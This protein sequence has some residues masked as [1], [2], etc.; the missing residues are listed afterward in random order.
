MNKFKYIAP[1]FVLLFFSECKKNIVTAT[2]VTHFYYDIKTNPQ[3]QL[4]SY[5]FSN[6][7]IQIIGSYKYTGDT[8]VSIKRHFSNSDTKIEIYQRSNNLNWF[9]LTDTVPIQSAFWELHSCHWYDF[10]NNAGLPDIVLIGYGRFDKVDIKNYLQPRYN[11]YWN[12]NDLTLIATRYFGTKYRYTTLAQSEFNYFLP[13]RTYFF[14]SEHFISKVM[15][16]DHRSTGF[17][18]SGFIKYEYQFDNLNRLIDKTEFV[19][20]NSN[21]ILYETHT[22]YK[23]IN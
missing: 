22:H 7:G 6:N 17:D 3:G 13:G 11:L 15:K 8:I 5:F 4:D 21:F 2:K 16:Y 23:Y 20:S 1:F 14:K 9:F 12:N 19:Y 18:D 10:S